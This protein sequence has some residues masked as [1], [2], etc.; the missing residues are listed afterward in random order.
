MKAAAIVQAA[1]REL[2]LVK[3]LEGQL[4]LE[5]LFPERPIPKDLI[6]A[7]RQHK[8]EV[9][10]FLIYQDQADA[11][12]LESTRRLA[13]GWPFDCPLKGPEWD[14][15]EKALH[16]AYWSQDFGRLKSTLEVREH[17]A[18]QVF[19]TYRTEVQNV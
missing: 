11:L 4:Q 18:L 3:Q 19:Q 6:A 8:S 14:A 16:D 5:A 15:Q 1:H 7:C 12:I 10:D 2:V 9:L 13:A 17:Y